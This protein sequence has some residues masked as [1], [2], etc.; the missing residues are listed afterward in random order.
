ML[1]TRR[2]G[3]RQNPEPQNPLQFSDRLL[4]EGG[5]GVSRFAKLCHA[6]VTDANLVPQFFRY[7]LQQ[8]FRKIHSIAPTGAFV[9]GDGAALAIIPP[10]AYRTLSG[11]EWFCFFGV[12]LKFMNGSVQIIRRVVR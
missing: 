4:G 9:T 2:L 7:P 5:N 11:I 1:G 10:A 8:F 12:H 6:G 3:H